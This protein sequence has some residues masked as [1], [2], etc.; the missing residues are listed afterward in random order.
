MQKRLLEDLKR[1]KSKDS[2]QGEKQKR[3]NHS[4]PDG[5]SK[6]SAPAGGNGDIDLLSSMA[7]RLSK[8]EVA[9]KEMKQRYLEVV[10]QLKQVDRT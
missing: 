5:R 1:G 8:A 6:G 10:D 7:Q 2:E 3:G 9:L 4:R